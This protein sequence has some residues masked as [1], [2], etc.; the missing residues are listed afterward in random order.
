MNRTKFIK[1]IN[2]I[3]NI[4]KQIKQDIIEKFKL[5][6]DYERISLWAKLNKQEI[7]DWDKLHEENMELERQK[8]ILL[9]DFKK[10][11]NR[12]NDM[13]EWRVDYNKFNY[14]NLSILF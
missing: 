6:I 11:F 14:D 3:P 1:Y 7:N 2:K 9:N 4:E 12:I 13:K 8:F 5:S 10:Q